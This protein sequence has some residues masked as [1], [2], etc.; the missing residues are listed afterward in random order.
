MSVSVKCGLLR[1][2]HQ[3][4]HQIKMWGSLDE[5]DEVSFHLEVRG[6]DN[7]KTGISILVVPSMMTV[8]DLKKEFCY[9]VT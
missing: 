3:S 5:A 6:M 7:Q 2:K 9:K 8:E 4:L 1:Q